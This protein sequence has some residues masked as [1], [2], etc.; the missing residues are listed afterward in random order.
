MAN[1]LR[2]GVAGAGR[3]ARRLQGATR[4]VLM[5]ALPGA[6]AVM[7]SIAAAAAGN[8]TH[9]LQ[10]ELLRYR[11]VAVA[12]GLDQ[13][14]SLAILPDGAMLIAERPGRLRLIRDGKLAEEP[15]KG[16]PEVWSEGEGGLLDV[17]PHPD[18]PR[19]GLVYLSY[20]ASR[21]APEE[22]AREGAT[23]MV[24]RGRLKGDALEEVSVLFAAE[25]W[26][27]TAANFGSRLLFA[28]GNLLFVTLGDRARGREEAANL[29]S[30]LGKIIRLR[31]DGS[32]PRDN[33]FAGRPGA[34]PE[35][36]SYGHV[37][38]LGLA[39]RAAL[40]QVWA[41]DRGLTRGG[42]LRL[43]KPGA[44][45]GWPR[46]ALEGAN[47]TAGPG[48]MVF[49][50]GDKFSSWRGNLFVGAP[51]RKRLLRVSMERDLAASREELL[52]EL[53]ERVRDVRAG[54]DGF[55]YVLT[56][57]EDGKGRLLRLEPAPR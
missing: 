5:M 24:A 55:L 10:S 12:A 32:V 42:E 53:D 48:G 37:D 4:L 27:T 40:R 23:T 34:R 29:G 49:Y 1:W 3:A 39:E 2:C 25:P 46:I 38:V 35:I 54:A 16:A 50:F 52:K 28:S 17:A 43:V 21:R 11:A 51:A 33:P 20:A 7:A 8:E 6:G 44:A 9:I 57:G 36:Y 15:V 45:R 56:E 13:P 30:D 31:D 18:F 41:H 14:R 19:N 47:H 26:A 22:P